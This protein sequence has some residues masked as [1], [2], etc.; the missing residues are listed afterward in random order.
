MPEVRQLLRDAERERSP[1]RGDRFSGEDAD[2]QAGTERERCV[3]E[4]IGRKRAGLPCP[5]PRGWGVAPRVR[6]G[7]SRR[8]R[9]QEGDQ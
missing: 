9:D 2:R 1:A 7:A 6:R 4:A 3:L 5:D 8:S